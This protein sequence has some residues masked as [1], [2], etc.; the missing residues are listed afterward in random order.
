MRRSYRRSSGAGKRA[1][2]ERIEGDRRTGALKGRSWARPWAGKF[3]RCFSSRWT[4][5]KCWNCCNNPWTCLPSRLVA[6]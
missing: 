2:G 6:G 5:K 4:R 1:R 3:V